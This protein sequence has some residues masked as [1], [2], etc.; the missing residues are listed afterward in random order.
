[1]R[2]VVVGCC[3]REIVVV[4]YC[5]RMIVVVVECFGREEAEGLP[6]FILM[7]DCLL[8]LNVATFSFDI[9][10]KDYYGLALFVF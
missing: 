4:G 9:C 8:A 10:Y 6:G 2:I 3:G 5:G 7:E 1:M